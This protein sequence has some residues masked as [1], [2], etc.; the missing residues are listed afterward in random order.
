MT[1]A[2]CIKEGVRAD[3]RRGQGRQAGYVIHGCLAA[4]HAGHLY[5]SAA[6]RIDEKDGMGPSNVVVPIVDTGVSWRL[7]HA[8]MAIH[9]STGDGMYQLAGVLCTRRT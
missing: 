3:D 2:K 4:G 5:P 8:N 7:Y 1:C 6:R 9:V